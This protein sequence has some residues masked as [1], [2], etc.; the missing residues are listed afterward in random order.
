MISWIQREFQHHFRTIFAVV[1]VVTIVSFI[2]T[3][4]AT[5]GV[6][7]VDR[8]VVV[9]D[10]FGHNLSSPADVQQL[11]TDARLSV[12]LEAGEMGMNEEQLKDYAFQ[13]AAALHLADQLHLPAATSVELEGYIRNLR[14]F[15]DDKGQFDAQRY[16]SF[17]ANLQTNGGLTEGDV[18]RVLSDDVRMGRVQHLLEGPGYVLPGDVADQLARTD[19]SW[20]IGIATVD[21]ASYQPEISPSDADLGKFY[22]QNAFRYEIPPRVV[23]SYVDFP[24]A[25]FQSQVTVT[26][27]EVRASYDANPARFP[28]PA[29]TPPAKTPAA[30]NISAPAAN[31]AADFAAVK[32]QVE[33][34]LK[35][36]KARQLAAK[37][38]SDVAFAL[39]EN[40]V[41]AGTA[42]DG[43]LASRQLAL[44]PLAPFTQQAGP[45]ELGGSSDLA[46]AAFKLT[47]DRYFS[48]AFPTPTGA[49]IVIWKQT[50]P[51]RK[52]LL[53][54]VRAK[55]LADYREGERRRRFVDLGHTLHDALASRL[56]AGASF[57]QAAAAAAAGSSVKIDAKVLP[58]FTLHTPPAGLDDTVAATLEHL[59]QGQVS[60]MEV[61]ADKGYLVYALDKKLPAV[62]ASNPRLVEVRAQLA[63]YSAQGTAAG[64]FTEM[65]S[66]ELKR[67]EPAAAKAE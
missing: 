28:A 17:R 49:A 64:Y 57:P 65:A 29:K 16:A 32:P 41:A 39:Y 52:P 55:V 23:A 22:D 35:Q 40:K 12:E 63:A 38:A 33:A 62:S 46:D 2:V 20:T 8:Q 48:E 34:A 67:I 59:G 43:F 27:D 19:T 7:R 61:A 18:A 66:Q 15:A 37:A 42:L 14:V 10:F 24:A 53:S 45:A 25:G 44:K 31:P 51:A 58:A 13:R 56:K 54:E 50:L 3:I 30:A 36:D 21:Y 60:D 5:P 47:S 26:D 11:L 1:L 6:G 9:R 4:G